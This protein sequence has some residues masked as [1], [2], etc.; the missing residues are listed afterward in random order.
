MIAKQQL[1]PHLH[2]EARWTCSQLHPTTQVQTFSEYFHQFQQQ[3]LGAEQP[4]IR[5]GEVEIY[6]TNHHRLETHLLLQIS[7]DLIS[8][9][10]GGG[11]I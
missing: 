8:I 6:N 4:S 3:S 1:L 2:R 9:D 10:R 7:E 11:L 5:K